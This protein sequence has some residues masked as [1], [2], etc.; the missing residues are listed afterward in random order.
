MRAETSKPDPNVEVSY[1]ATTPLYHHI[2]I[3]IT[4]S[5]TYNGAFMRHF[6]FLEL[7]LFGLTMELSSWLE[8]SISHERAGNVEDFGIVDQRTGQVG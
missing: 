7:C 8:V 5:G 4:D 2:T 3:N 6:F 1:V